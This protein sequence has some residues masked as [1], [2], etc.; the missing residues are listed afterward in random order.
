MLSRPIQKKEM[1]KGTKVKQ[2]CLVTIAKD[3]ND[4]PKYQI[5][6]WEQDYHFLRDPFSLK[7]SNVWIKQGDICMVIE[8]D[9][10]GITVLTPRGHIG[11][12]GKERMEVIK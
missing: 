8:Q 10:S 3:L 9:Y 11:W 5:S 4:D 1:L 6:I 7:I 12:I 2:G